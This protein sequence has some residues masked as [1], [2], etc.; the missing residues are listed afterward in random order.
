MATAFKTVQDAIVTALVTPATIVGTRVVPGRA[1]PMP[2]EH[3]SD[4]AVSIESI[5]GADIAFTAA[6]KD[7]QIVYGVEIR[8]RGSSS[9]DG[10]AALDPILAAAYARLQTTAPPA[11]VLGWILQPR[12]RVQVEEAATPIASMLLSINVRLR[13]QALRLTLAA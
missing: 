1:R 7:W 6:P 12:I 10:V 8:A 9:T 11:G 3:A 13:T 5:D 4:I 2:V